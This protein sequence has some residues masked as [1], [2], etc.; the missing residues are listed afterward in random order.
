MIRAEVGEVAFD[1]VVEGVRRKIASILRRGPMDGH[2]RMA[3][4]ACADVG[5]RH[6]RLEFE[7]LRAG[8]FD[9]G[10]GLWV[11]PGGG[12]LRATHHAMTPARRHATTHGA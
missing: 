11:V 9:I 6:S 7:R 4:R 1:E 3:R 2:G 5:N 12:R 8:D 10:E